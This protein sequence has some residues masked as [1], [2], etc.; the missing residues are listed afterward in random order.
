MDRDVGVLY[1][2]VN[3]VWQVFLTSIL[4]PQSPLPQCLSSWFIPIIVSY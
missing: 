1:E 3:V 2:V 4:V